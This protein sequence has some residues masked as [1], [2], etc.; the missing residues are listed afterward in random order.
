MFGAAAFRAILSLGI[1]ATA[2]A[3]ADEKARHV[4]TGAQ[5]LAEDGFA[6]LDGA[7]VGLI[8]NQTS[9][10]GSDH[11]IDLVFACIQCHACGPVC[12]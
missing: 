10:A 8:V 3:V 1:T 2:T 4:A 7:R 9:R 12:A 6:R 11:L 5:V